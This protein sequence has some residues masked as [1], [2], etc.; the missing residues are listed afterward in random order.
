M[1]ITTPFRRQLLLGLVYV[2]PETS[3]FNVISSLLFIS[4][5][6]RLRKLSFVK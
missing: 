5:Q 3:P 4:L 1:R 2:K 6:R